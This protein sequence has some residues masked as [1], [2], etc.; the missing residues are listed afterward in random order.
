[1]TLLR[2][3]MQRRQ[4]SMMIFS[5]RLPS[6]PTSLTPSGSHSV[7]MESRWSS[8]WRTSTK[9]WVSSAPGLAMRVL[10]EYT[11]SDP[12]MRERP[13]DWTTEEL[14]AEIGRLHQQ[15]HH[16]ECRGVFSLDRDPFA[17]MP[18]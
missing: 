8:S 10:L 6:V 16:L 15:L 7:S 4:A 11:N 12:A 14:W 18:V 3:S 17:L 9:L 13:E 5:Y 2:R 1:M